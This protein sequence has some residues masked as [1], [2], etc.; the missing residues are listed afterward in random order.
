MIENSAPVIEKLSKL[1]DGKK[2]KTISTYDFSTLYTKLPH[3]DLLKN[4]D[5]M[6]DFVFGCVTIKKT[7]TGNI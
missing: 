2:A 1:N 6:V 7:E 5:R 4:L 3:D